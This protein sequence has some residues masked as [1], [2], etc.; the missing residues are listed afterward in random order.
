MKLIL[1]MSV[2]LIFISCG[3]KINLASKKEVNILKEK[4]ENLKSEV[5][6]T[7]SDNSSMIIKEDATGH[8]YPVIVSGDHIVIEYKYEE[9]GEEG[10]IDGDYS[11]TI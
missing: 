6:V 8:L 9:K 4:T 1:L 7:V 5:F 3:N 10:T 11:I 2:F